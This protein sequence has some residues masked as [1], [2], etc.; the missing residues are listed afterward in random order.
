MFKKKELDYFVKIAS[1]FLVP[2][3]VLCQGHQG[4]PKPIDGAVVES[5]NE[6]DVNCAVTFRTESILE[7]F[8]LRFSHLNIDCND[9]LLIYDGEHTYGSLKVGFH[10][11]KFYKSQ[12][13][14]L[15]KIIIY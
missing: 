14:Y 7:K 12:S 15:Y 2:I 9:K 8:M 4:V 5:K 10:K 6:R 3:K 1:F 13:S 11:L